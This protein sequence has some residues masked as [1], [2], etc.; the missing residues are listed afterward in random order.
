V[1]QAPD[2]HYGNSAWADAV[3]HLLLPN[4]VAHIKADALG[5]RWEPS[6]AT[7]DRNILL[8][9]GPVGMAITGVASVVANRRARRRAERVAAPAWRPLGPL[10]IIATD[11]RLLV[12]H[13]AAWWSVWYAAIVGVRHDPAVHQIDL[14]FG[15]DAPYRLRSV[16]YD[17]LLDLLGPVQYGMG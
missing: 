12:W 13:Q 8:L 9:G 10:V 2:D 1:A 7:Y 14:Y 17:S 6:E 15:T 16:D 5:W 4:E 11:R 3:A